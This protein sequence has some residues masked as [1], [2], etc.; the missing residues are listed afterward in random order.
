VSPPLLRLSHRSAQSVSYILSRQFLSA[1]EFSLT[2]TF[3]RHLWSYLFLMLAGMALLPAIIGATVVPGDWLVHGPKPSID[4]IGAGMITIGISLFAFSLTQS[5]VVVYG[6]KTPCTSID[7]LSGPSTDLCSADIPAVFA[8][9][10][11]ILIAFA[12]FQRHLEHHPSSRIS[13][14]IP[15]IVKLS[16]FT[17]QRGRIAAITFSSF[18]V[19]T[20]VPGW[21]YLTTVFYQDYKGLS[22]LAS[23]VRLIP[24]CISGM[25]AAVSYWL[26]RSIQ[27][28]LSE[29]RSC[30]SSTCCL[31]SRQH[32][33]SA[34]GLSYLG[35]Q[36]ST[37]SSRLGRC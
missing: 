5:G 17:R 10:I 11:A 1:D 16:L 19:F 27:G 35:E 37:W 12:F 32:T 2:S 14:Q 36:S 18:S 26:F 3:A 28:N 25:A 31:E 22:P 33:S 21:I 20:C 4:W 15:P 7:T 23:A 9:S 6:W 13:R 29:E 30:W 34:P 8:S 24:A